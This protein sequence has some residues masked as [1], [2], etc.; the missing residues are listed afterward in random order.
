M[1]LRGARGLWA[2]MRYEP[3]ESGATSCAGLQFRTVTAPESAGLSSNRKVVTGE[4][5]ADLRHNLCFYN[6]QIKGF[7]RP[8]SLF[9]VER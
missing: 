1:N 6:T 8:I 2:C 5:S 7:L 4:S 9:R 3:G